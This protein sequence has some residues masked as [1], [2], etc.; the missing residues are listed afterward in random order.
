MLDEHDVETLARMAGLKIDPAYLP[1]VTNNLRTL[2]DQVRG[3]VKVP[4][5]RI[6]VATPLVVREGTGPIVL[7]HILRKRGE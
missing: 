1:G 5:C 2:L 4:A 7:F 3:A 6:A